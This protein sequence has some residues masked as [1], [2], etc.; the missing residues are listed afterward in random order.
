MI[1]AEGAWAFAEGIQG[2]VSLQ[3]LGMGGNEIGD[4]GAMH[5]ATLL[6]GTAKI[7]FTNQLYQV[8]P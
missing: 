2:N 5:L 3:W 7:H 8:I 6:T 1:G 4:R